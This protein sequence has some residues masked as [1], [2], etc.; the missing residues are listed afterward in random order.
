MTFT[1]PTH[2][3]NSNKR[4]PQ[5][6]FTLLEVMLATMIFVFAFLPIVDLYSTGLAGSDDSERLTV[7]LHAAQ[8]KME[9]M[10]RLGY[11]NVAVGQQKV[12]LE[13]LPKFENVLE[14]MPPDANGVVTIVQTY[15]VD[16]A[17]QKSASDTGLKQVLVNA[18]QKERGGRYANKVV[19]RTLLT[20]VF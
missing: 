13:G 20:G 16:A 1:K 4:N 19:L 9:S 3:R 15:F 17:N 5:S 10:I 12:E 7:S 8:K 14:I 18:A 6:G 2:G 11:G